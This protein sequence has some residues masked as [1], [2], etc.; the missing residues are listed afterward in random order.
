MRRLY[1]G[2]R[3]TRLAH[4]EG[5]WT[6]VHCWSH[7]RRRFV[8]L[9]RNAKSA[10]AETAVRDIATLYAIEADVRGQA[11]EMRLAARQ[12][13]SAPIVE[14]LKPNSEKQLSL[15]YSN[16]TLTGDIRY[17]L[18]HR[19]G[20]IRFLEDGRLELGANPVE[21]A[22]RPVALTRKNALFASHQVTAQ[23]CALLASIIATC[24]IN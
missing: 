2:D 5:P 16:S 12:K 11:P 17:A 22:I 1:D 6:L 9:L 18:S 10:I 4:D 23:D 7:W 21:N 15:I 20:L 14:D 19:C 13:L 8:K 24:K 3:L